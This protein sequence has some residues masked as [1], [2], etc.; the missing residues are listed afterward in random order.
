MLKAFSKAVGPHCLI[1]I[2]QEATGT[3][4]KN[5]NTCVSI[6]DLEGL[7]A[8]NTRLLLIIL[9]NYLMYHLTRH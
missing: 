1:P 3:K 7:V 2:M 8:L 5:G 9:I 6:L 4:N